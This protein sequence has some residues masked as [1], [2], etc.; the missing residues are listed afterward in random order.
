MELR[1]EERAKSILSSQS[2]YS[3]TLGSWQASKQQANVG[4]ATSFDYLKSVVYSSEVF[5]RIQISVAPSLSRMSSKLTLSRKQAAKVQCTY[6]SMQARS[7]LK[8]EDCAEVNRFVFYCSEECQQDDLAHLNTHCARSSIDNSSRIE[9]SVMDFSS[10]LQ[11]L[12]ES[13]R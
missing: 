2:I 9:P 10:I 8:C 6:C 4:K 7:A 1:Q 12:P 11:S 13:W 3:S 5:K